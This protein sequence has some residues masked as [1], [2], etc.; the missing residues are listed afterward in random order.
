[1][2][3]AKDEAV[4]YHRKSFATKHMPTQPNPVRSARLK[5]KKCRLLKKN[6]ENGN[7]KVIY[8]K[9]NVND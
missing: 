8:G 9:N 6:I 7:V 3:G 1:M 2:R 4:V 5:G